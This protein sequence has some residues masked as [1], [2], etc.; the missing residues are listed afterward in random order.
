MANIA[1][2]NSIIII[3][4]IY[5]QQKG[6][7][8]LHLASQ[9]GS[10]K[11][12]KMLTNAKADLNIVNKVSKKSTQ[13]DILHCCILQASRTPLDEA[14]WHRRKRVI[15]YFVEEIK[16]DTTNM[17]EVITWWYIITSSSCSCTHH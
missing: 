6:D 14:V 12:A 8:A 13:Y 3:L 17:T 11:V 4:R 2:E 9:K 10:T 1:P 5:F 16:V 7:T 15:H